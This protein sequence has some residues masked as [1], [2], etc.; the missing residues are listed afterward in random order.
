V[1]IFLQ[2]YF[3]HDIAQLANGKKATLQAAES[4]RELEKN[5]DLRRFV[6][7]TKGIEFQTASKRGV[8]LEVWGIDWRTEL[9]AEEWKKSRHYRR[10]CLYNK[11]IDVKI[12][13]E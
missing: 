7:P 13:K 2:V 4:S 9:D 10:L 11:P 1:C 6:H 8:Q 3:H 5:G 12:I